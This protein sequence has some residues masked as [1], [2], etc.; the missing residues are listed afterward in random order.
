MFD[1]KDSTARNMAV[2]AVC[3][4]VVA[5]SLGILMALEFIAP[6]LWAGIQWLVFPR[7]RQ[8][9]VNGLAFGWLS[10]AMVGGLVLHRAAP[11][12]D[13][14]PLRDAR[15]RRRM[16]LWNIAL[17]VGVVGLLMGYTQAR[18]YAELAWPIDIAIMVV[19]LLTGY[20]LFRPSRRR[21]VEHL[22]VS[23]W[24]V[25]GI[26]HLVPDRLRDRQRH[27]GAADRRARWA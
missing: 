23:L 17:A 16:V 4:L 15:H 20:N 22:Y 24:Y 12:Q 19:L 3:W 2:S 7:I 8:A 21:K 6:D 13:R 25:M 18:E 11:H 14:D 10:M 9:H 5:I 27:L 26:A 1:G